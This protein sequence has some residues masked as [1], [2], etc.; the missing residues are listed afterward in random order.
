MAT[1]ANSEGCTEIGPKMIHD[2]EPTSSLPA[3]TPGMST[4][5]SS[6]NARPRSH[7]TST[8]IIRGRMR[9]ATQ[10]TMRPATTMRLWRTA[11]FHTDPV[12]VSDVAA[13][14]ENTITTPIPTSRKMMIRS[15]R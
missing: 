9:N 3:P 7:G 8:R 4:A 15:T 14:E 13:D 2:W 12:S 6:K 11:W 1:R 10:N 5:I